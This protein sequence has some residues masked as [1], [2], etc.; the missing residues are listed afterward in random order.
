MPRNRENRRLVR[1]DTR[2]GHAAVQPLRAA[3]RRQRA[4]GFRLS[5]AANVAPFLMLTS[6]SCRGCRT[7]SSSSPLGRATAPTCPRSSASSSATT[8]GLTVRSSASSARWCATSW[9]RGRQ[10]KQSRAAFHGTPWSWV[11]L[12]RKAHDSDP[13]SCSRC[14]KRMKLIAVLTDP[15]QVPKILR[16]LINKGTPPPIN[17]STSGALRCPRRGSRR[18]LPAPARLPRTYQA[19]RERRR[20]AGTGNGRRR[21]SRRIPA[22]APCS[23]RRGRRR[24]GMRRLDEVRDGAA[25]RA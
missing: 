14:H 25:I 20:N 12:I 22:G 1:R 6:S 9:Q 23:R 19:R 4:T 24:G 13:L 5:S 15:A 11:R 10:A 7:S 16:H 17:R 3:V 2:A 18:A 8:R 21:R